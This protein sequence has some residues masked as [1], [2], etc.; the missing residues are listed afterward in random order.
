MTLNDIT[1]LVVDDDDLLRESITDFLELEGASTFSA[2]NGLKAFEIIQESHH[3][4]DIIISDIRMPECSGIDLLNMIK[5]Y[6]EKSPPVIMMSSFSDY[7][8]DTLRSLGAIG[9]FQKPSSFKNLKELIIE[10][11]KN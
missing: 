8:E 7:S 6:E 5:N 11:V 2:S 3:N 1:V 4:I 10:I 9:M